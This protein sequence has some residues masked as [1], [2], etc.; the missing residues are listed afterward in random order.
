MP[1][2]RTIASFCVA[3]PLSVNF[4]TKAVD[5][6]RVWKSPLLSRRERE[7]ACFHDGRLREKGNVS[8]DDLASIGL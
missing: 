3:R 6:Q 1:A 4:E 7:S 2:L 5:N 8:G